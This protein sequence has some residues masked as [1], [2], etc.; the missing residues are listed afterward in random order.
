M[1]D[2]RAASRRRQP[3]LG[4][5]LAQAAHLV[6]VVPGPPLVAGL[7]ARPVLRRGD[8][9]LLAQLVT[10]PV[11]TTSVGSRRSL[12]TGLEADAVGGELVE[13]GQ[14]GAYGLQRHL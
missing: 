4:D 14:P 12:L 6:G 9:L 5:P 10:C 7:P 11:A 13:T 1:S 3:R 8:G 2:R